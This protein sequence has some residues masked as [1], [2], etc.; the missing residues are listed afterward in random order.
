MKGTIELVELRLQVHASSIGLDI[1]LHVPA[2]PW[3]VKLTANQ[4]HSLSL[5]EV[6]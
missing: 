2:E 5:T 1:V 4:F 3:P 6:A